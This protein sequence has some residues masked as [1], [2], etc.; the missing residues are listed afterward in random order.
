MQATHRTSA[1]RCGRPTSRQA[2]V[3]TKREMDQRPDLNGSSNSLLKLTRFKLTISAEGN[4][5]SPRCEVRERND[6]GNMS[7]KCSDERAVHAMCS[8]RT[9]STNH[10]CAQSGCTTSGRSQYHPYGPPPAP[11]PAPRGRPPGCHRNLRRRRRRGGLSG[12]G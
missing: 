12:V 6:C 2:P 5:R 9:L 8:P 10:T 1:C 7:G 11:R 3:Q 4:L